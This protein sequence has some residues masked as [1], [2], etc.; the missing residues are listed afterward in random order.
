M[1]SSRRNGWSAIYLVIMMA[2][3]CGLCS[4]GVDLGRVQ[5]VKTELQRSADAAARA[6]A[7]SVPGDLTAA[8]TVAIQFAS[9]NKADG[10]AVALDPTD[11]E[12]GRWNSTTKQFQVLT[13]SALS[14]ADAIR[15]TA[16]RTKARG[17]ATPLLFAGVLGVN[18]CD[19]S[20]SAV[21]RITPPPQG[22][23]IV[24]ING[25]TLKGNDVIDSYDSSAGP[26]SST[27]SGA[28]VNVATN[29]TL[30]GNGSSQINGNAYTTNEGAATGNISGSTNMLEA[31]LSYPAPTLPSSYTSLGVVDIKNAQTLAGGTYYCTS[32]SMSGNAQLTVSGPVKVYV[33]GALSID[34]NAAI[35]VAGDKP[36]NLEIY[37]MGVGPVNL[38][39]ND[40]YA[41]IYCPLSPVNMNG[42]SDLFGAVIAESIHMNGTN[43]IHYDTTLTTP[44]NGA[45]R[46]VMVK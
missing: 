30:Y 32:F 22:M 3:L 27:N 45:P 19:A 2:V 26:Y 37:V 31:P 12:F 5:L 41:S 9:L 17:N 28:N 11:I 20:R 7:A 16:R 29:G 13:G 43:T 10:A 1:R 24:G 36:S 39:K 35:A 44:V 15:V 38:G 6:G 42:N 33:Q 4:F 23:N 25:I 18:F 46:I 14:N 34:G 8:R 21:A 40:L